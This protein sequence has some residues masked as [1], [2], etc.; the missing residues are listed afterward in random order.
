MGQRLVIDIVKD[1]EIKANCYYHWSGYTSDALELAEVIIDSDYENLDVVE[2]FEKTGGRLENRKEFKAY[3]NKTKKER[4]LAKSRDDGLICIT[5]RGIRENIIYRN[6]FLTINLDNKTI[7][8]SD[9]YTKIKEENI[10]HFK[11]RNDEV[12]TKNNL[13]DLDVEEIKAFRY[14]DLLSFDEFSEYKETI[15]S[16]I[17]NKIYLVK[18]KNENYITFA[19]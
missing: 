11:K 12:I 14:K 16:L 18:H 10:E 1:G 8:V 9:L 3:Y 19:E 5:N 17:K 15:L 7:D 6:V 13:D 2:L 4:P